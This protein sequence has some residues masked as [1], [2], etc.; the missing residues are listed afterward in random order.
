MSQFGVTVRPVTLERVTADL[1]FR[2]IVCGLRR[3]DSTIAAKSL[4]YAIRGVVNSMPP[5]APSPTHQTARTRVLI[6]NSTLHIGGAEQVAASLARGLDRDQ[7]E[8]AACYLKEPGLV[9]EQMVASGVELL[10]LPGF[11]PNQPDY[12][13]SLK[14]R[15]LI[16]SR[17]IRVIHTHDIH[18]MIDG[19]ICRILAP[20]VRFV[21][22]FHFGN[23]PHR[24]PHYKWIEGSLWRLADTLVAVGHNQ[25]NQI[26][27]CFGIPLDR[28]RVIWNG[29]DDPSLKAQ[30]RQL[31]DLSGPGV[32]VIASVSTLIPQKG[33]EHL[34]QAASILKASGDRFVL[35]IAGDGGLRDSLRTLANE[36]GLNECVRFLGWVP[37]A[38]EHLLPTCDIFVQSSL[39]EAMSVVVLEAMASSKPMVVTDV[40]ENQ[41]VVLNERTGLVVAP[42]DPGALADGLR[43]LLRDADLRRRM[44]SAA[45]Q[46]YESEFTTR[47][48]ISAHESL[49][50]ELA[51]PGAKPARPTQVEAERSGRTRAKG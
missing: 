44:G 49:Y 47:N 16:R 45:R 46:R 1:G 26:H 51:G 35:V 17:D 27:K 6:V 9:A 12:F 15:G 28:L 18:G 11:R 10:H 29:V 32:P 7:F 13:T 48:M 38:S 41:H 23:Y 20:S 30:P 21:H 2:R 19:A 33:L 50:R 25:A 5:A 42:G 34:L 31:E 39:W 14:L 37:Q 3:P 22:T 4:P 24:R 43:R 36:L 8:V 40:G